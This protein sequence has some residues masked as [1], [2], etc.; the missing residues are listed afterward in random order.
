ML[1]FHGK[2]FY[3]NMQKLTLLR[4][5]TFMC[6]LSRMHKGGLMTISFQYADSS[7]NTFFCV[8]ISQLK[9]GSSGQAHHTACSKKTMTT[10]FWG[11]CSTFPNRLTCMKLSQDTSHMM[12]TEIIHTK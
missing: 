1:S 2:F 12:P 10:F 4:D 9:K 8:V 3:S 5:N 6:C 11:S 7:Q